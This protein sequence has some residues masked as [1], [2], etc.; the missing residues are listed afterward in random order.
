MLPLTAVHPAVHQA[1]LRQID[2]ADAIRELDTIEVHHARTMASVVR[3]IRARGPQPPAQWRKTFQRL[4]L[5]AALRVH[6]HG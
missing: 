2:L 5:A 3:S 6:A 4:F 1:A